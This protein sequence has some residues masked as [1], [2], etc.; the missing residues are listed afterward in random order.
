MLWF[1]FTSQCQQSMNRLICTE[2]R[3]VKFNYL[4]AFYLM[5]IGSWV[6]TLCCPAKQ[7]LTL[8]EQ[9]LH[10]SSKDRTRCSLQW[11]CFCWLLSLLSWTGK[12]NDSWG[13]AGEGLPCVRECVIEALGVPKNTTDIWMYYIMSY[14]S[15]L[16]GA[17]C[18]LS[19]QESSHW[20][21]QASVHLHRPL[22]HSFNQNFVSL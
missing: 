22:G 4:Q 10:L 6:H 11:S 21:S 13:K 3:N 2:V 19:S 20:L 15:A 5:L 7:V 12:E 17:C 8:Q 16:V 14:T 9:W 1:F 18:S